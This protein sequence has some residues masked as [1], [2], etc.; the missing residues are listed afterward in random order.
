MTVSSTIEMRVRGREASRAPAEAAKK[1]LAI[2][3]FESEAAEER[4]SNLVHWGYGT[5]WGGVRG[6]L[7][8]AGLGRTPAAVAHLPA[9]WGSAQVLL[10]TLDVAPPLTM[11]GRREIAIDLWHHLVYVVATGLAYEWLDRRS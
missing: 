6:L 7:G 8:A 5:A 2:E 10:P 11:W 3:K 9:M 1:V 4:F